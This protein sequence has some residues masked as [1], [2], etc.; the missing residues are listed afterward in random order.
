MEN[1]R[2]IVGR[3]VWN[4][5]IHITGIK[6]LDETSLVLSD[7]LIQVIYHYRSILSQVTSI[8]GASCHGPTRPQVIRGPELGKLDERCYLLLLQTAIHTNGRL[9][10]QN[11]LGLREGKKP[12]ARTGFFFFL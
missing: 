6:T 5:G 8:W 2:N 1:Q 3:Y 10:R 7:I 12:R 4:V 9:S 11:F